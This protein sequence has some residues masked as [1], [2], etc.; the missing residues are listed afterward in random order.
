MEDSE[1]IQILHH[2]NYPEYTQNILKGLTYANEV[3]NQRSDH[4]IYFEMISDGFISFYQ[5][6]EEFHRFMNITIVS[7][8][9]AQI[10]DDESNPLLENISPDNYPSEGLIIHLDMITHP[11][12]VFIDDL[13][14]FY[15][16]MHPDIEVFYID[17]QN[18]EIKFTS[19][20]GFLVHAK[21]L[22]VTAFSTVFQTETTE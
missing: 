6:M 22:Y 3:Y 11:A 19:Y 15:Q 1:I 12:S 9:M 20:D 21:Y 13:K 16:G 8:K 18:V 10:P 4:R 14:E 17:E 7:L 5:N 2:Y